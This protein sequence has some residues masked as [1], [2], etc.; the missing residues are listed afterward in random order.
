ML[1]LKWLPCRGTFCEVTEEFSRSLE[2]G[3][4]PR[5]VL[6]KPDKSRSTSEVRHVAFLG[7]LTNFVC[8]FSVC[9]IA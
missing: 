2:T 6:C 4:R 1:F 9:W 5:A 8:F 7:N 3:E